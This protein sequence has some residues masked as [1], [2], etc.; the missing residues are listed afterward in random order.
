MNERLKDAALGFDSNA[1]AYERARPSYPAEVVAHV[2]GHGAIGPG[3]RVIDLAAGTGKLTRLLVPTGADVVA[4]EPVA[5]MRAQLVAALPAI[6]VLDGTAEDLPLPDDSADA[7]TVAQAF[8]WFDVPLALAEIRRVLHPGGHLFLVWNTR[9]RS[10]DWVRAFGDLLVD[11]PDAE[12][13]YDS[14][15]D[16]D[17]AALVAS[18]GAGGFTPVELWTHPWEQPCDPDLLVARAE[19]VSVVG[20]LAGGERARVLD[21]VRDLARTHPDLAGRSTFGFPYATRV[22]RCRTTEAAP[23]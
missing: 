14:Y 22:Y 13:P 9:D 1:A 12:R 17:Y 2:V 21:R 3:R 19:S 4:V 6:D 11:G 7:V 8:H 15:Y 16:V 20:A 18:A 10:H 5:G 23:S